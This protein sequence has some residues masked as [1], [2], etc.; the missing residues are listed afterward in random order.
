MENNDF[1]LVRE[2]VLSYSRTIFEPCINIFNNGIVINHQKVGTR[3]L[4]KMASGPGGYSET[5]NRQVLLKLFSEPFDGTRKTIVDYHFDKR[6]VYAPWHDAYHRDTINSYK[7]WKDDKSFLESNGVKNYTEFF[8]NNN[9]DIY[10]I[11]RSPIHRFFSGVLEILSVDIDGITL[12]KFR[13]LIMNNWRTIFEDVHTTHYLE[14]IKEMI[15]NIEDKSKIKIIDLSHLKSKKAYEF[16]CKLR[17]DNNIKWIYDSIDNEVSS[18][19]EI[20]NYFYSLY[21]DEDLEKASF[22]RYLKTE[23]YY[24]QELKK[25]KY[26]LDLS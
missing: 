3:F 24:Y 21:S 4:E 8:F 15:Y 6:Y 14:H 10:F 1:Q 22:V 19:K 7:E 12:E 13:S 26:F 18:N 5:D 2:Y 9:K 11:I 23:Y 16:F 20:Y 25:S 17:G